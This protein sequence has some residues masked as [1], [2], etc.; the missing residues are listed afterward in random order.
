MSGGERRIRVATITASDTRTDENDTGGRLL[1]ELLEA[2][3]F[4]LAPH[5]I[6][7]EDEATLAAAFDA[8]LADPGIDA[9]VSTGGTGIAPRDLTIEVLAPR[10][11]R[12]LEGFG[13]AFRRLSWDEVGPRS[14]LSRALAGT[15]RGKVLVALPGSLGAVKLGVTEVLAPVLAHAVALASGAHRGGHVAR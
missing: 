11:E 10:L 7:R 5:A 1:R 3:G 14:I 15:T 2:A 4:E 13:E 12:E 8:L 9:I 6:V